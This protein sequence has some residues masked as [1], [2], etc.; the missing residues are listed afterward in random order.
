M[1]LVENLA[2]DVAIGPMGFICAAKFKG[3][4]T[5]G[6]DE[7]DFAGLENHAFIG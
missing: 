5:G 7:D 6:G 3:E 1:G 4:F 2:Q